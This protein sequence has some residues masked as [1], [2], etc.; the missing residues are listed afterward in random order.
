MF[1]WKADLQPVTVHI[2]RDNTHSVNISWKYPLNPS[3]VE[4]VKDQLPAAHMRDF[5]GHIP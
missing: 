4:I 5:N 1:I 2:S 3:E